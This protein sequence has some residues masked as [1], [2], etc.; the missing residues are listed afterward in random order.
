[1]NSKK[2]YH[3]LV[4]QLRSCM[5]KSYVGRL[6]SIASALINLEDSS[7]ISLIRERVFEL[8]FSY[9]SDTNQDREK[10][11]SFVLE[12]VDKI[13]KIESK[14]IISH[15]QTRALVKNGDGFEVA[16]RNEMGELKKNSDLAKSL[17]ALKAQITDRLTSIDRALIKKQKNRKGDTGGGP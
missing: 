5:E 3:E 17:D 16:L 9:I 7:D 2:D 15:E 11:N 8:I 1:M 14:L 10:V 6:D 4:N 13:L 12:I